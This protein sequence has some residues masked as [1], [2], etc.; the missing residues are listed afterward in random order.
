MYFI[1]PGS[2]ESN[3]DTVKDGKIDAFLYFFTIVLV[4]LQMNLIVMATVNMFNKLNTRIWRL[5]QNLN[6]FA[7]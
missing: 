5:G 1:F 6:M 7:G 4:S 3:Q 2:C